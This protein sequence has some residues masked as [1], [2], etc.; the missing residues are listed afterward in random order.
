MNL[1]FE[2]GLVSLMLTGR[3]ANLTPENNP[4]MVDLLRS[5]GLDYVVDCNSEEDSSAKERLFNIV[6]ALEDRL[7]YYDGSELEVNWPVNQYLNDLLND[8]YSGNYTPERNVA[9]QVCALGNKS[10][11][12]MSGSAVNEWIEYA[13]KNLR[14]FIDLYEG[15]EKPCLPIIHAQIRSIEYAEKVLN[16]IDV[17]VTSRLGMFMGAEEFS[18]AQLEDLP[19][20]QVVNFDE[21]EDCRKDAD[22]DCGCVADHTLE[23]IQGMEDYLNG[24]DTPAVHYLIGVA[25]ANNVRLSSV[26]GTEG[27]ILDGIK[28]MAMK[29]WTAITESFSAIKEWF[30]SNDGEADTKAI[31]D[32][33][34]N[35]K[36]DLAASKEGSGD[37]INPAAKA[38]LVKLAAEADPSGAFSAIVGGL[39]SKSDAAACLDKLLGLLQKQQ[40]PAAGLQ[41]LMNIAQKRLADLKSAAGSVAGKDEKNKEVVGAAKKTVQESIA[42]TKESIKRVKEKVTAHKKLVSGIRKA[43][44]GIN[45]QI[46]PAAEPKEA[47]KGDKKE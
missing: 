6:A 30:T 13:H 16:I 15:H 46:F 34:E 12:V 41:E 47:A 31:K 23:L 43:V 9:M 8:V 3:A 38:G 5:M 20:P 36:K 17:F 24:T 10:S 37:Q 32:S 1:Y 19:A 39:N 40:G 22:C 27:A 26:E 25:S 28:E 33:A 45:T 7:A 21:P 14:H 2:L 11:D 35:N 18:P 44:S 4:V 29:A 42:A